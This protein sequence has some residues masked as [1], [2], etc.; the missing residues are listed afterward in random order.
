[1]KMARRSACLLWLATLSALVLA[2]TSAHAAA[3][4]GGSSAQ[5]WAA[6]Q[7]ASVV[8]AGAMR[9]DGSSFRASDPIT[10]DE[11]DAALT[12]LGR[13]IPAAP[14]P[15]RP[16][17]MRELDARVVTALGVRPAA[18]RIR[19]AALAAGLEPTSMLGTE[20]VARLL[21]L[22][23]NHPQAD[24]QLELAPD[25]PATRAE[26]AY[27]LARTMQ[28]A[29]YDLERV[30]DLSLGFSVPALDR[31]QRPLLSR[32]LRLVG[33]PYVWAGS[34]ERPQQLWSATAPGGL[35]GAPG[36]FDC[37][38]LVWRVFKLEPLD[39]AQGLQATLQGR[40][41]YAMAGEVPK[42]ERIARLALQPADIVFFGS[43]G[44]KSK[45]AE[46]DHMG[47]YVGN[48]WFV[49]SST[50]GVTLEPLVGWY[51]SR[52][53]WGRRPLAEAGLRG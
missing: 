50:R 33:S 47:I 7:I 20:T 38:G 46:V 4:G 28:L 21:G 39:G 49:H 1:M 17:T 29:P 26:A 31:W 2:V 19:L 43:R 13:S 41:S 16:V 14:D 27:S 45:P 23:V 15:A 32:A 8:A 9:V 18:R 44:P 36:G 11:L 5:S 22:R 34:S 37:S 40:T 24:E 30:D 35:I 53:A 10:R 3:G 6:G 52:F 48:G 25:Q 12:T 42:S 51:E